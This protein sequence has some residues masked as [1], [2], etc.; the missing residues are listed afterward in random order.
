M[1]EFAGTLADLLTGTQASDS[2]GRFYPIDEAVEWA[3]LA[4]R[5]T[6]DRGNK[7]M[8]IGN[9]GSAGTAS[10]MAIDY[11]KSGNLRA[12]AMNDGSVLTC[13]GNDYGYEHVFAKQIEFYGRP[14]DFLVAL[15][16]SG[17]SANI[18][19]AVKV[20]REMDC[21]VMTLSG[22]A[23]D[24]PL[25]GMGDM[26]FF[27]SADSY[28]FVEVGHMALCHAILEYSIEH[29]GSGAAGQRP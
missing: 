28:V 3:A 13:L 14:G 11:S 8:F 6:H 27:L 10:H 16:S 29:C 4:A 22:F 19:N 20:A 15:S 12:L 7:L 21:K 18:L 17:R 2:S 25:R 24:N 9:G 5:A 1:R 23:P 26:N